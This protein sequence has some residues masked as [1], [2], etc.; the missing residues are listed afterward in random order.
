MTS[1]ATSSLAGH[2]SSRMSRPNHR[3]SSTHRGQPT[4][5]TLIFAV[6]VC[7]ASHVLAI[8]SDAA[9][10]VETLVIDHRVPFREGQ[11]WVMLSEQQVERRK[12]QK[13][14]T[15]DDSDSSPTESSES[16]KTSASVSVTTTFSIAVG[17]PT[18][19]TTSTTASASPLPSIF[20]SLPS[21]FEPG[22]NGQ[23]SNCPNFISSFLANSTFQQ[24]YPLSMLFDKSKSFFEAQRSLV[25]ITRT[26]DATCAANATFCSGYLSNLARDLILPEN[27]GADYQ[28]GNPV[29]VEAHLAMR[30]YAP[31]YSAGCLREP[32]SGAYCYATA[33]TNRTNR[34]GNAYLYFLPLN[35]TLPGTT[36]PDCGECLR[37]TMAVYQVATADRRQWIADTYVG[38]A[39]QINTVCGPGF[40]NETLAA[41]VI[42]S[43]AA[44][45][46]AGPSAWFVTAGALLGVLWWAV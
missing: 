40:V 19:S 20:D 10:P 3:P 33:A 43:G 6:L 22:P 35:K 37:Q 7:F 30:A 34:T 39:K 9:S 46:V 42:P 24:C 29:I 14:V 26:L 32:D 44:A 21:D 16:S 45:G 25:S 28:A 1:A 5:W 38:A 2:F 15:S 4:S 41:A 11:R 36:V 23:P 12:V 27:C 8:A 31:V 18:P 13:R 17:K